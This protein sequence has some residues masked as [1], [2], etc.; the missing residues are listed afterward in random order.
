MN[1]YTQQIL[2]SWYTSSHSLHLDPLHPAIG[3]A[4]ESGELLNV[5]KKHEFKPGYDY[6]LCKVCGKAQKCYQHYQMGIGID[7]SSEHIYTP[8]ILDELGDLA[9]YTLI[10]HYQSSLELPEL[11]QAELEILDILIGINIASGRLLAQI[12]RENVINHPYLHSVWRHIL[13]LCHQLGTSIDEVMKLND[14]KLS[15]KN[16]NGWEKAR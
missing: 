5:W 7:N 8:I 13:L 4:G 16:M 9:Y 12:R 6:W 3:L 14:Q 10:L 1:N 15:Q 11:Y 2:K